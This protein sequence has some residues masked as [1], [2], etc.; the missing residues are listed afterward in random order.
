MARTAGHLVD[1]EA[2]HM[3]LADAAQVILTSA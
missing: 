1:R 3:H 2:A